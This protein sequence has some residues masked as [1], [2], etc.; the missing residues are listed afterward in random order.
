[1]GLNRQLDGLV[2]RRQRH[3]EAL[4]LR[5]DRDS[6]RGALQRGPGYELRSGGQ[7][8]LEDGIAL[9]IRDE[10]AL[11]RRDDVGRPLPH[12]G[13]SQLL[14]ALRVVHGH[15]SLGNRDH[16]DQAGR[17]NDPAWLHR[18]VQGCHSFIALEHRERVAE[19]VADEH[20][21]A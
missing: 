8:E 12:V 6:V 1:L 17:S 14:E 3:P 10:R 9:R 15:D 4:S 2:S 11:A 20:P 19:L 5:I 13:R 7:L 18:R 16:A 21:V